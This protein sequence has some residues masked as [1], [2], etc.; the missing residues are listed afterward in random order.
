M[1][2]VQQAIERFLAHVTA[3]QSAGTARTYATGLNRFTDYLAG[4]ALPS[5]QTD[6]SAL[7]L[8]VTSDYV[9]WLYEYLLENVA[10]GD[11]QRVSEA[12]KGTYYA[13]ISRFFEY[14]VIETQLLPL[15]LDEY[16][17]LRKSLSRASKRHVRDEL[18]P[19]KLPR[20]RSSSAS[21]KR[22]APHHNSRPKPLKAKR[23]DRS[24]R[25]C[26]MWR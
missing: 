4:R 12:T 18:P 7:S 8:G 2:T 19:D 3:S 23:G 14:L 6:V 25:I 20:P 9:T 22:C 24:W 13:A 21:S 1:T 11:P 15:T 26:A 10:H 17:T 16:D 5:A